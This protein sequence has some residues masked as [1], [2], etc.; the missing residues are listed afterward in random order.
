MRPL[1]Q[2]LLENA[3]RQHQ[4]GR[5]ADAERIYR[6]ILALDARHADSLHLLG[7]IEYQRGAHA[8]ALALIR[9][10]IAIDKKQAAYHSNLGTVL[11]GQGQLDEAA[12]SYRTALALKPDFADAHNH[13]GTALSSQGKL[14]EAILH[15]E[16]ALALNPNYADAHNNLG[17]ALTDQGKTV[18]A[19]LHY[20]RALAL[21]PNHADAFCNLGNAFL[22]RDEYDEAVACFERALALK[23]N[24]AIA[25]NNLGNVLQ[26]LNK[27]EAAIACYERALALQPD[28]ADASYGRAMAKLLLLEGDFTPALH[29]YERR[30]QTGQR[31]PMRPYPH[32]LWNGEK[33]ASGRLLLWGEQGVGDEIMF[34][35]LIPDVLRL[36]NRCLL[37]CDPRLT[38][39]LARSYPEID[40][41]SG[42]DPAQTAGLDIAAHLPTGSLPGLFRTSRDAFAATTSPY[43]AA[44]PVQ[45]QQF[46]VRYADGRRLIGLAWHTKNKDT[47]PKRS[48]DLPL[49]TPLFTRTDIAW[50]SLQYG[51]HD[52]LER[53]ATAAQAPIVIDRTVDQFHDIDAFA[54]QIAALDLVIT[55]DNSTAHLAGALG[56]P[57]W[58][59]LPFAPDWR[60]FRA[61]KDSL[62][63]P[64][65]RLF[66]QPKPG[67]W[68]SVVRAVESAL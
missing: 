43:L 45:R 67:D 27:L 16:R 4:A 65:M 28:Y 13:L 55:I 7:L 9:Q 8:A 5:S 32:P 14:A 1:T 2:S 62:W 17:I 21:N 58:L 61:R 41:V 11:Q 47:G 20:G 24:S 57:V 29:H 54:A 12:A 52:G 25:H 63:Y 42:L 50:V 46:R 49:L 31:K 59:L 30:W 6:Q 10:A 26:S 56:V 34:A 15:Y 19:M 44:D 3:I 23:P 22:A 51:D 68:A 37:D 53:Q 36:G 48:I 40:V 35:G 66:R 33:L 64:S 38:N 18:D 39:L 60:W